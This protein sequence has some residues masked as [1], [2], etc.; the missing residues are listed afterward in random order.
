MLFFYSMI[1]F[2]NVD[3]SKL[4]K[5]IKFE[6]VDYYNKK[7]RVC[8]LVSLSYTVVIIG[9]ILN[10]AVVFSSQLYNIENNFMQVLLKCNIQYYYKHITFM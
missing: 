4:R 8:R 3:Y 2:E 7:I 5:W 1:N 10:S 9:T 6:N